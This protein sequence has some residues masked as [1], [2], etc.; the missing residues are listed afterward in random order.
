MTKIYFLLTFDHELPLGGIT[1]SYERALFDPTDKLLELSESLDVPVTLFT[2][3]LCASQFREWNVPGFYKSWQ[4]QLFRTLKKGNDVQLHLHPHWLTSSFSE[5]AYI[6]SDDFKLADFKELDYPFN[7]EGIIE[8]A[9][10]DLV[11]ICRE[12][13]DDYKCIAFRGGGYNLEPAT[14]EI[15]FSLYNA[16]IRIDCSISRG[17]FT[18]SAL[19][20]V[21]YYNVP[22]VP[23]WYISGESGFRKESSGGIF[24]IPI[25]TKAKTFFEMPTRYKMQKVGHRAP[26]NIGFQIHEGRPSGKQSILKQLFSSRMLSF[27]NYTYSSDYLMGILRSYVKKYINSDKIFVCGIGH[28]K[29]MGDYSFELYRSF[30][31]NARKIYGTQ[32]EFVTCSSISGIIQ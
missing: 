6:P 22:S 8:C 24:E 29:S 25:A 17:Y 23:N 21:D 2:D 31:E 7:I 27:D 15:I 26:E 10:T 11:S 9:V 5:G 3:I 20:T 30:V 18:S 13:K 28:P 19:S 4:E 16:G 14:A 12:A 32:I 1:S